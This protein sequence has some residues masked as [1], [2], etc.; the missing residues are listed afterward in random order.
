MCI[1]DSVYG[2][3]SQAYSPNLKKGTVISS[4][5]RGDAERTSDGSI[6]RAGET[7]NLVISNGLVQIPSVTGKDIG[8]ANTALTAIQLSV[9]LTADFSCSGNTVSYQSIIGDQPQKSLITLQY[10]AG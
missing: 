5:P 9:K 3:S 10:C 6:I 8:E 7:V 4:D 1:R 2:T